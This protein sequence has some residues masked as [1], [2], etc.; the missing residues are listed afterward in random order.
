MSMGFGSR[1]RGRD[2]RDTDDGSPRAT[3][4]QLLP[5]LLEHKKVLSVVIALSMAGALTTLAQPLI[6]GEVIT[7]VESIVPE[8]CEAVEAAVAGNVWRLLVEPGATVTAEQ[9]VLILEAMKMEIAIFAPGEG[10]V[11]EVF[12]TEGSSVKPG[13]ALMALRMG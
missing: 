7:V 13:Q 12:V 5:F 9:P 11:A 1:R 6:V 10:I 3:L 8:G 2:F 4:R